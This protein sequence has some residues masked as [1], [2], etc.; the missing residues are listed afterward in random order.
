M[1][2]L[3]YPSVAP[4]QVLP[5]PEFHLQKQQ[6]GAKR[7]PFSDLHGVHKR[8]LLKREWN[9]TDYQYAAF[10]GGMHLL[11]L[12]AP[13]TFSWPMV[14][15]FLGSYFVSGCLGI[16]LSYHRCVHS[17]TL[18][19][20]ARVSIPRSQVLLHMCFSTTT[21]ADR[22]VSEALRR[23]CSCSVFGGTKAVHSGQNQGMCLCGWE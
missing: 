8:N 3:T 9:V 2:A 21:I 15:L 23:S 13:F 1:H 6:P 17:R 7:V 4:P 22:D 20:R 10:L 16:T 12:A 5:K 18:N 19:V 14:F 11:A